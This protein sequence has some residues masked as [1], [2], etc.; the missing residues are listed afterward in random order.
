[1]PVRNPSNNN[2]DISGL[3][4]SLTSSAFFFVLGWLIGIERNNYN[5][6]ELTFWKAY[7]R[8]LD[9]KEGNNE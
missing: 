4:L 6:K 3:I 8:E 2:M 9:A 1:V 7:A 5:T